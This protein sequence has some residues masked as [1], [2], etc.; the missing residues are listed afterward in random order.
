MKGKNL[1]L[2]SVRIRDSELGKKLPHWKGTGKPS[3]KVQ[4]LSCPIQLRVHN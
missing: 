3:N 4:K 1:K 2:C